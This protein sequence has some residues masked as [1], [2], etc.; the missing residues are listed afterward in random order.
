MLIKNIGLDS[1]STPMQ[2]M[3]AAGAVMDAAVV[4]LLCAAKCA[5]YAKFVATGPRPWPISLAL[6]R[7]GSKLQDEG[8]TSLDDV[9]GLSD[10][11]LVAL[12]PQIGVR[13][14]VVR[15]IARLS[16]DGGSAVLPSLAA[17]SS[18]TEPLVAA[19]SAADAQAAAV[20][21]KKAMTATAV[22]TMTRECNAAMKTWHA[23]AES[24]EESDAAA[25]A[26]CRAVADAEKELGCLHPSLLLAKCWGATLEKTPVAT[27]ARL[28]ELYPECEAANDAASRCDLD[29]EV[30]TWLLL[31]DVGEHI[32]TEICRVKQRLLDAVLP[33]LIRQPN[34]AVVTCTGLVNIEI[35]AGKHGRLASAMG[36]N[37]RSLALAL[38][39]RASA[40]VRTRDTE[41]AGQMLV[42]LGTL[43]REDSKYVGLEE[44]EVD[45][46]V[47]LACEF[48]WAE[49]VLTQ[50][51]VKCAQQLWK[52]MKQM[53]GADAFALSI[54]DT[55]RARLEPNEKGVR[56]CAKAL[57]YVEAK[58]GESSDYVNQQRVIKIAACGVAEDF[59]A[60][61]LCLSEL[62]ADMQA[63][64]APAAGGVS[65]EDV[66]LLLSETEVHLRQFGAAYMASV[67]P[68]PFWQ[69]GLIRA[70]K[71]VTPNNE[72]GVRLCMR[73]LANIEE[74]SGEHS[75]QAYIARV[76][77]I[78]ACSVAKAYVTMRLYLSELHA[79]MQAQGLE[80]AGGVSIEDV[81]LLLRETEGHLKGAQSAPEFG[82]A[83]MA[84]IALNTN[85]QHHVI[86]AMGSLTAQ[87]ESALASAAGA[88]AP[89][90]RQR[91]AAAD[92]SASASPAPSDAG[93][94]ASA[95]SKRPKP[96]T[97]AD[98][99]ASASPAPSDEGD[100]GAPD[101]A[102]ASAL[103]QPGW[104]LAIKAGITGVVYDSTTQAPYTHTESAEHLRV[105]AGRRVDSYVAAMIKNGSRLA[106]P[107]HLATFVCPVGLPADEFA[108]V[109]AGAD[110]EIDGGGGLTPREFVAVT[111]RCIA[112]LKKQTLACAIRLLTKL[113]PATV[114]AAFAAWR[115]EF[116]A[117]G[118]DLARSLYTDPAVMGL[119][120]RGPVKYENIYLQPCLPADG[121]QRLEI[122]GSG[123]DAID[124]QIATILIVIPQRVKAGD[125]PCERARQCLRQAH[126]LAVRPGTWV[127]VVVI[128]FGKQGNRSG[129][130]SFTS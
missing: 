108:G 121:F 5:E 85:W 79:D 19:D 17:S 39:L 9:M 41:A 54:I 12:I 43:F 53:H 123:P 69:A 101:M 109:Y 95:P 112:K 29:E 31:R 107:V 90:K 76:A 38:S 94:G 23:N 49:L 2:A 50:G 77:L 91:P 25:A 100:L 127:F 56:L 92:V 72:K 125:E 117:L 35:L 106:S 32:I 7:Y 61:R 8:I 74:E 87:A 81:A 65:I 63:K 24:S 26:H 6:V 88:S 46:L 82:A 60:M 57:A 44:G 13:N 126:A 99:S 97:A 64:G 30:D 98:A 62:L 33:E 93:E 52:N 10:A 36:A 59:E 4:D 111:A 28:L 20:A 42:L 16:G 71:S 22:A 27:V 129:F 45:V 110:I 18:A 120:T 73:L 21:A 86:Y 47:L 96:P 102:V 51:R 124:R 68:L 70:S 115:F 128:D 104:A 114:A 55:S 34:V 37:V 40:H 105:I 83:H 118:E 1:D 84:S 14:R 78:A 67:S 116:A 122:Y 103:L 15:A 58:H 130:R 113:T 119:F 3:Q 75:D 11:D 66:A 89:S 80:A 48:I